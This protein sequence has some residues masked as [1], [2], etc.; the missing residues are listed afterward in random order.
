[1]DN[2]IRRKLEN[3][4]EEIKIKE[5]EKRA[6]EIRGVS[7]VT[8]ITPALSVRNK[9]KSIFRVDH[10]VETVIAPQDYNANTLSGILNLTCNDCMIWTFFNDSNYWIAFNVCD[11]ISF[12]SYICEKN[13][14]SL[15]L[16]RQND[17]K[18]F[19]FEYGENSY[20]LRTMIL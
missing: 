8:F 1:M 13:L 3:K 2:V 4:K 11:V 16:I 7:N 18:V 14:S 12:L 19:D 9:V 17:G 6:S 10:P 20:E 5:T 15:T